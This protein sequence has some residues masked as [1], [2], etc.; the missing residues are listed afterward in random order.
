MAPPNQRA[1]VQIARAGSALETSL[2]IA[3]LEGAGFAPCAPGFHSVHALPY[4]STALGGIAI[5]VPRHQ[6]DAARAFL[7]A[8]P[9]HTSTAPI[10][11]PGPLGWLRRLLLGAAHLMTGSAPQDRSISPKDPPKGPRP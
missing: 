7:R 11:R 2:T 8:L 3:A 9:G 10:V 6:A 1:L 4:F 5:R